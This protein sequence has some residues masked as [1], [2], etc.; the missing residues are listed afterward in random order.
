MYV[1]CCSCSYFGFVGF[2]FHISLIFFFK[3]YDLLTDISIDL[4]AG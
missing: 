1:D 4:E 2:S 3:V